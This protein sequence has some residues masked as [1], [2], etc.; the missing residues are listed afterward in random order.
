MHVIIIA[1][2][3][4]AAAA[5]LVGTA[6]LGAG[7]RGQRTGAL[8]VLATMISILWGVF[9]A[10]A[11]WQ[12]T[13]AVHWILLAEVLHYGAW[14]VFV[15]ALFSTWP[16]SGMLRG[17]H[18]VAHALWVVLALYCLGPLTGLAQ[19]AGLPFSV[20]VPL[21]GVLV[22]TLTGLV[23]LEQIY[24][25]VQREQR[26]ALKFLVIALGLLFAYGIFLYSYAVLY[27]EFNASAWA[28]RGFIDALLVPLLLVAAARNPQWSL[29]VGVSRRA[30]FYST[31]LL[32]VALYIIATAIG[33]YYVR[34]Y[35]GDWG[36]VA[37]ITLV[38]FALLLVLLIAFSGQARSRLRVFLHKNFFSFRHDYREEW[39]RLTATLSAGDTELP[40]R[41]VHAIAQIMDSPAGALFTR[42]D[43]DDFVAEARWNMPTPA[44][45]KFP[46][47]M[48]AFGLMQ[49]RRWIYD[50]SE[51]PPLGD[52]QLRAPA[53]L[54]GLP[55]AWLLVPLVLEDRLV[56]FVVLAHARARRAFDWEDIDLLRAA[57]SQVAGILAQAV[58]A[59]RLAE[60]RQFEGFNRLT[61]FLMHDLKNL[62]A[63]QSL[64]LQNAE[65]HRHNPAFVDDM[66]ATVANSVQRISR[67][68]E[69]LRG[70][71]APTRHGRVP[72]A[73]VLDKA[74]DECHA[75][76]PRPQ[77]LPATDEL[78]VQTDTDQLA[79][80]LGHVIRN[81]QDAAQA[82]GHVTLRVRHETGHATIEIEDD[83]AGMDEDFI[84][85]RLFKPFFT[86]KASKG[87]GIGA[88]QARAYVHS[89]GGTMHVDSTPGQGSVFT[90]QL[91]LAEP[92]GAA[93]VAG[94]PQAAP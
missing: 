30:V 37:E 64:L 48:P 2:Y 15:S 85:N 72:L 14:I 58:D 1:S 84:H 19:A 13:V 12:R 42:D 70:D 90:I 67:L 24:R 78:W 66:L 47:S 62:A 10:Y 69:Q 49:T 44:G 33:G 22:L 40:Q 94:K 21:V 29:D 9:L 5:F 77:Y 80:V 11:E 46:A 35:G 87:M 34:L 71:A 3:L 74:L 88:Y 28:A 17:L 52:E 79:T 39:L 38:C 75:Q 36:R 73:A 86:T 41:A 50:L 43:A 81:A 51:P 25:N 54:T 20:N 18:V 6:L 8:L 59:R 7:W 61:A 27:R 55:H 68:L 4:T 31:S 92:A 45:L 91:P 89:L 26:W 53:E 83:G 16:M 56:G 93:V 23:F 57:G 82:H 32:V 76:S 63:Q 60:A 65:R